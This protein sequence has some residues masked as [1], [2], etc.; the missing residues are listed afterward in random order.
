MGIGEGRDSESQSWG[1]EAAGRGTKEPRHKTS[2]FVSFTHNRNSGVCRQRVKC[3]AG[4]LIPGPVGCGNNKRSTSQQKTH[5]PSV[6]CK[7]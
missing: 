3:T 7:A 1:E 2:M 6:A 4:L 5:A